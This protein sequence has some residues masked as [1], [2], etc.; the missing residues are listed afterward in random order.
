MDLHLVIGDRNYSSW[1]M[2]AWLALRA[3]GLAFRTTLL[4]LDTPTALAE[5]LRYAPTA[6]VP[7][8]EVD[9]NAVWDSLAICERV[10]EL[11]PESRLWP[12]DARDRARARALCAEMHSGF[13]ALRE[14]LALNV[15]RDRVLRGGPT[16]ATSADLARMQQIFDAAAGPFMFGEFGI[17]DAF[18]APVAARLRSYRLP[19]DGAAGRYAEQLLQHAGVQEWCAAAHDETHALDAVDELP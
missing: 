17:V 16:T 14:Q 15:R 8:L 6:R 11:A 5:K 7:V 3:S 1:S 2:R 19:F 9:G 4:E 18:F 12:A 13:A 10:A